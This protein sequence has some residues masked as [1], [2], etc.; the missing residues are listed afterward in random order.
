MFQDDGS[1]TRLNFDLNLDENTISTLHAF[2]SFF[3]EKLK[4]LAPGK[5]YHKLVQQPGDYPARI[6]LKV[7]TTGPH[8]GRMWAADKTPLG[9]A[10]NVNT[11]GVH[12][13]ACLCFSKCWIMG[14]QCGVVCE[15]RAAVLHETANLPSDDFPL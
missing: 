8:A 9:N 10:R 5:S 7:N 12:V 13:T 15:L 1:A 2:D 11:V 6:R 4:I 3:E 14:A